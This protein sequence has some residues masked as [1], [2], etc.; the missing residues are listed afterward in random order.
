MEC[1]CCQRK[2]QDKLADIKSPYG[3]IFGTPFGG[4]V[5][6]FGAAKYFTPISTKDK[7]RRVKRFKSKEVGI[8]KVQ[9][10]LAQRRFQENVFVADWHDIENNVASEVHV[11][12][13]KHPK[14][15]NQ[16]VAGRVHNAFRRWFSRTRRS[17]IIVKLYA[18]RESRASTR[19]KYPQLWARRVVTLCK[20]QGIT[21][22]K[23]KTET[24]LE[25]ICAIPNPEQAS[26]P[27]LFMGGW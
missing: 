14:C 6:V 5:I 17:R 26:T 1:F 18:T 15:G 22:C 3:R 2:V 9:E 7:S 23:K 24:E 10:V 16:D 25:R 8:K 11:K 19:C 4:P 12:R 21:V 20:A 13:F 27:R